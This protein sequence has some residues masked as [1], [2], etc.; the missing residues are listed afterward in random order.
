MN[1]TTPPTIPGSDLT[2]RIAKVRTALAKNGVSIDTHQLDCY[3]AAILARYGVSG[4]DSVVE[5][6]AITPAL[7][8]DAT[9]ALNTCLKS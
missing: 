3:V 6:A 8:H 9:I 7:F 5:P 4:L 2:E 1:S